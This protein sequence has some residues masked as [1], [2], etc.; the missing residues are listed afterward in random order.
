MVS[1]LREHVLGESL[2]DVGR[3][4]ATMTDDCFQAH[5]ALNLRCIGRNSCSRYYREMFFEPFPD[6]SAER[7]GFAIGKNSIYL[8]LDLVGTMSGPWLGLRPTGRRFT[9]P[10]TVSVRFRDGLV[11]GETM[12][13]DA[14]TWCSQLEIRLDDVLAAAA[15][16]TSAH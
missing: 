13:Y 2:R 9:L 15:D 11:H 8:E 1:A 12:Y 10:I 5:P 16:L 6:L 7:K 3:T 4:V 14:R